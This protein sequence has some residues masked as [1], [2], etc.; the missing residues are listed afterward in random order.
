MSRPIFPFLRYPA[1][2]GAGITAFGSA[3]VTP[4]PNPRLSGIAAGCHVIQPRH[5]GMPEWIRLWSG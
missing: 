2:P 5:A 1:L 3:R 4:Q